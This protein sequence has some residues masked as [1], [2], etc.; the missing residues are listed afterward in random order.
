[1][2][3][4]AAVHELVI[5][6]NGLEVSVAPEPVPAGRPPGLVAGGERGERSSGPRDG[7]APPRG[8]EVRS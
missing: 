2:P 7:D 6:G 1:M 3:H 8:K 5:S 4:S